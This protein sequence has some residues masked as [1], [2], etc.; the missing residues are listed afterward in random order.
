MSK[1]YEDNYKDYSTTKIRGG[2]SSSDFIKKLLIIA[3]AI[4]FV[5]LVIGLGAVFLFSGNQSVKKPIPEYSSGQKDPVSS[6]STPDSKLPPND[7]NDNS[8]GAKDG[9]GFSD[10][11]AEA[12]LFADFYN[13]EKIDFDYQISTYDLPINSKSDISNFYYVNRIFPLDSYVSDLDNFGMA[14]I[15]NPFDE[16]IKG[17]Y[18]AYSKIKE[19]GMP[20]FLTSDFLIYYYQNIIKESYKEIEKTVFYENLWKTT[21]KLY[22][23]SSARYRKD[24]LEKGISNDPVLEGERLEAAYF[25][26][27][28]EL[29]KPTKDQVNKNVNFVD[30]TK[31]NEQ[32]FNDYDFVILDLIR[33]DV[34]SEVALIRS[35]SKKTNSPVFIYE[36]NY[37]KYRVPDEYLR[38]AKL[39]NFYLVTKWANSLFPLYFQDD[40]CPAC[41]LDREDWRISMT[42]ANFIAKDF[43]DNQDLKNDWASVY[44]I[45]SYFSGL[46]QDL[47]YLHFY[48]AFNTTFEGRTIEDV[49]S[50]DNEFWEEDYRAYQDKILEFDFS[51]LEGSIDRNDVSLNNKLG[52]RM[53][54]E[55]YWPNDF[56]FNSLTG[57]DIYYK[58]SSKDEP[59]KFTS[60]PA[61][62]Q[63]LRN[64]RCVPMGLDIINIVY[65]LND[66]PYY[67]ENT[68]YEN[69][70]SA[71]KIVDDY[72]MNF[73]DYTWQNNNYWSTL[74][75]ISVFLNSPR[76]SLPVFMNSEK[77]E[78]KSIN[79]SLG[80]WTNIHLPVDNLVINN[81][82]AVNSNFDFGRECNTS[83]YIEPNLTLVN[84]L[85]AK[86]NMLSD[87]L[88]ALKLGEKTNVVSSGLKDLD[89]NLKKIKE[90]IVKE[91]NNEIFDKNDCEFIEEFSKLYKVDQF[92]SKEY[93]GVLDTGKIRENISGIKFVIVVKE[94][95]ENKVI[96]IGPVFNYSEKRR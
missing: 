25:A 85:I 82:K 19:N 22:E 26:T 50:R 20:M 79:T 93:V 6:T 77:W 81:S 87:M 76:D 54:Q 29:L 73:T 45:I 43:F 10:G 69:F 30:S 39:K 67:I 44:K 23:I 65:P 9:N 62:K 91:L 41:L 36:N 64:V 18:S 12:L 14:I 83:N 8:L 34:L 86:T 96:L 15:D 11:L 75:T 74:D 78:E 35:A 89:D 28:L 90:L 70:S 95:E 48:E 4:I 72:F 7:N 27:M 66:N 58:I 16:N 40:K 3:G 57:E 47:T 55:N 13:P 84:D 17:F 61:G 33:E 21:K 68:D 88:L 37:N 94:F 2:S 80:F 1:D 32:E 51:L 49:F 38:N 5:L 92:S 31:F 46:R 52:M 24:F 71:K 53:L 60:C 63:K 59:A 56:I 42:A